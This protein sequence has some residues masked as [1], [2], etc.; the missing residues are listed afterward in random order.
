MLSKRTKYAIKIL[1]VLGKNSDKG[2][3]RISD[4]VKFENIPK[5]TLE[6]VLVELKKTGYVYNKMGNA[7]VTY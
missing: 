5:K 3:L 2:P 7:A 1:M 4:L 6:G